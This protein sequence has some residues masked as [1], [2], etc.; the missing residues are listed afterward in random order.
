MLAIRIHY[1][2]GHCYA[3]TYHDRTTPEWPPHPARLF[4]A[5]MAACFETGMGEPGLAALRWLERQGAPHLTAGEVS[6]RTSYQAPVPVNDPENVNRKKRQNP[7]TEAALARLLPEYRDK[8]MRRFPCVAPEMP[9]VWLIW[10]AAR[11]DAAVRQA[12]EAMAVNVVYL[13]NS[14][15]LVAVALDDN[16][17]TPTLIPADDG[18]LAL[19][20]VAPGRVD[21]LIQRYELGLYPT[22]GL[23]QRYAGSAGVPAAQSPSG[24]FA[25]LIV[26]RQT[27]G[28]SLGLLQ[29]LGLIEAVRRAV[30][31]LAGDAAPAA[32]HGHGEHRHVAWVPL[33]MV[34][35]PHADGHLLGIGLALPHALERPQRRQIL[36]AVARLAEVRLPD[37]RSYH[38]APAGS[39]ERRYNLSPATWTRPNPI[40]TTVTPLILPHY[41][42]AKRGVEAIIAETCR[43]S[44]L[45]PPVEVAIHPYGRLTG[46]PLSSQF[47]TVR[48]GH[49]Q[50]P[51]T[52]ATVRFA[53]PVQGPMILGAG[54]Y[55]GMGLCR[56]LP[57]KA[58]SHAA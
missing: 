52:H 33:P 21:E 38:L 42:K 49:L 13:G 5:L 17:P 53:E 39:D 56:A 45:P 19:R 40:W 12:L 18:A 31:A 10:P 32:L 8:Q 25:E 2:S 23:Y 27:G 6:E 51:W 30:L 54:R 24:E 15:S 37:G 16:P 29:S 43:H 4:S 41:P 57:E 22:P 44:G 11:P 58:I 14:R 3:A 48:P 1:L 34:G 9:A 47:R 50:R 35:S 28:P 46:T 26:L 36:Q 7:K 55:F 20:G